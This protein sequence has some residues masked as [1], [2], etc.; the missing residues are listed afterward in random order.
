MGTTTTPNA[1]PGAARTSS[2]SQRQGSN[3]KKPEQ[4]T[5]H[6]RRAVVAVVVFVV[7]IGGLVL[8]KGIISPPRSASAKRQPARLWAR[9]R[10]GPDFRP[11]TSLWPRIRRRILTRTSPVPQD[12]RE[13]R[14][15]TAARRKT[16][17]T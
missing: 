7:L 4:R 17:R 16:K 10:R 2:G 1:G 6:F 8:L 5:D 11:M 14:A 15:T 12:R 9:P 3:P 13:P